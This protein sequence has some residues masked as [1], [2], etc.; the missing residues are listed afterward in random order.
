MS[1]TGSR[2]LAALLALLAGVAAWWGLGRPAAGGSGG[3][4]EVLYDAPSFALQD[5]AGDTLRASDL[6][7]DVWILHVFFTSCRAVC[8]ATTARMAA[9]RDSLA[10]EGLLGAEARLVSITVDPAR[11]TLPALRAWA[12]RHGAGDPA[13]W[14]FLRG[15]P[16]AAVRRLIQEGF[17]LSA[18]MPPEAEGDYQV[19][20]SPRALLVDAEGRIQDSYELL[21]PGDFGRLLED[22][23]GLAG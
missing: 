11:D 16:P 17:H 20:H 8:P 1:R 2:S 23:R 5:Q 9:L 14:A 4:P 12:E 7:G 10:S 18:M 22:L 15:E 3:E 13:R 19:D 6:R 21:R